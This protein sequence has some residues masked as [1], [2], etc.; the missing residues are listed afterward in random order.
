MDMEYLNMVKQSFNTPNY[1]FSYTYDLTHSMQR[2][3]GVST[4]F[5][6]VSFLFINIY[7]NKIYKIIKLK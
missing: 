4:S 5:S 3:H 2:L 7:K 1:Y 6:N